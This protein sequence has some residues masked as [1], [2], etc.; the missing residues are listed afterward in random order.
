MSRRGLQVL[1]TLLVIVVA[2][3]SPMD[4]WAD[5]SES[6]SLAID[7]DSASGMWTATCDISVSGVDSGQ[8][9]S[10]RMLFEFAA[11]GQGSSTFVFDALFQVDRENRTWTESSIG[12]YKVT[13]RLKGH[14]VLVH[15][16]VTFAAIN[17]GD[18]VFCS[19]RIDSGGQPPSSG[20]TLFGANMV[21]TVQQP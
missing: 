8:I 9:Y 21:S 17:S 11:Q 2:M 1:S 14:D 4:V 18:R 6:N 13:A 12:I 5:P 16:E 7:K 19:S 15:A 3:L 10:G 20:A